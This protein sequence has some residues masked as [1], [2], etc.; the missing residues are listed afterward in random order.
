M[1]ETEVF[2]DPED[3]SVVMAQPTRAGFCGMCAQGQHFHQPVSPLVSSGRCQNVST[4][5]SEGSPV[6]LCDCLV[7]LAVPLSLPVS[8]GVSAR[9][10]PSH[11]S[12]L[13]VFGGE[14]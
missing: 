3:A 11:G 14:R 8:S 6:A 2:V 5:D 4:F 9:P 13:V 10:A 1:P 7:V 12:A